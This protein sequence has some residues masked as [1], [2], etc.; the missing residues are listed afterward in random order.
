MATATK[1]EI[2]GFLY[3]FKFFSDLPNGFNFVERKKN[4]DCIAELGIS[5]GQVK[6]VIKDLTDKNYVSGPEPDK[7]YQSKKVWKFG[8]S[9]DEQELYIKLAD[10]LGHSVAKCISFHKA[11]F[12]LTYPY[13]LEEGGKYE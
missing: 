5:I 3:Q 1:A 9:L 10:D 2:V 7:D 13:Q 4:M 11:L 6:K 8:Y 12:P